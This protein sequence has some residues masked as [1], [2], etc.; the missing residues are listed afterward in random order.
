MSVSALCWALC[1]LCLLCGRADAFWGADGHDAT[2][3]VA[4]GLLS[5]KAAAAVKDI[6]GG[7][8][9]SVANWADHVKYEKEWKWSEGLHYINTPDWVCTFEYSRDCA[10]DA[11]VAGAILNF[12]RQLG[13][14]ATSVEDKATALK[15]VV[16]FLGDIH[17]PLHVGFTSDEGGNTY[18]GTFLSNAC[19][20]H[21]VWD[22]G[23][24]ER[25]LAANFSGSL[26]KYVSSLLASVANGPFSQDVAAWRS[27]SSAAA[28]SRIARSTERRAKD[29][30]TV[31]PDD[32]AAESIAAACKFA[33]RDQNGN[34]IGDG[35]DLGDDYYAFTADTVDEQ[36]AKGGVRLANVLN[37]I[38]G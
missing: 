15:F 32:W 21:E 12:T 26:D 8:M 2:A 9:E 19:N 7:D 27:C 23:I 36:I 22:E 24:L 29:D 13:D 11:C 18:K 33:Y 28:A 17:Q 38:L 5:E 16:H 37:A 1:L 35:F 6:L 34:K 10:N 3:A 31:C 25:T 20:L 14:S 4:T 30:N